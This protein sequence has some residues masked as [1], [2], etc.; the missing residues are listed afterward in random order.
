MSPSPTDYAVY[1]DALPDLAND[2]NYTLP[3]ATT[4]LGAN[5]M[6]IEPPTDLV[7]DEPQ[8]RLFVDHPGHVAIE[9]SPNRVRVAPAVSTPEAESGSLWELGR[10]VWSMERSPEAPLPPAMLTAAVESARKTHQVRS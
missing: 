3:E 1:L 10:P 6:R 9:V 4:T 2:L 7:E 8:N 5:W